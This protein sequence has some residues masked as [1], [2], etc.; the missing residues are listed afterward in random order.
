[1]KIKPFAVEEW[2]N[3]YETQASY[4]IAETCVDSVSLD[5]LLDLCGVERGAFFDKLAARRLTYGDILG[6]PEYLEGIC[7]LYKKIHPD[8]LITTHGAAGANHLLF[9]SLIEPGDR[10]ISVT[11]TYQQ[12]YS[13]P[14]S[15]GA[16]VELLELR[17]ENGWLPD[18]DELRRMTAGGVKMICINNPN[19][20]TGALMG[21]DLLR[22][23][24][25]IARAAGAWL[26][27]DEVYRGLNQDG[28]RTESVADLYEKGISVSSMSKVFSMA[29]IRLG[30]IAAQDP[31]V[32]KACLSHRDY[33]LISCGMLDEQIA[34][35]ALANRE[36]LLARNVALV[37]ENLA[38]LLDWIERD[39]R[40]S[41]VPPKAGTTALIQYHLSQDSVTFCR[42][43]LKQTGALVVPGDCFD[44]P[45]SFRLGYGCATLEL[46][47]GLS[48]LSAY[49]DGLCG[50]TLA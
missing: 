9:Y 24:V 1:M 30:W 7:G 40:F 50:G 32:R 6:A 10:V 12:L 46:R 20:P 18:P 21:P 4:N 48:K 41:T 27:C 42:G 22:E 28:G 14:A 5:G 15:F 43:L 44:Q 26:L 34:A 39:P 16:R 23:I 37:Q 2:M 3:R 49:A 31:A 29:G 45:N 25:E 8:Q 13:I 36:K 19:N 17:R 33:S 47:Q 38:V 11:P 35:L